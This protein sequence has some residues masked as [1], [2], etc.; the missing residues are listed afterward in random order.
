MKGQ[1][2]I[3]KALETGIQ[4][5]KSSE[6]YRQWLSTVSKFHRY[7][8][9]NLLLIAMQKP[10]ASQVAGYQTW[11]KLGRQVNGG[12]KGIK[13][14]CP[15]PYKKTMQDREGN[16]Q[17]V[18]GMAFAVGTVFDI[19]QTTGK[20]LPTL[21]TTLTADVGGY[22]ALKARLLTVPSVPVSF[23]EISGTAKG[24]C[25]PDEIKVNEGMSEAQT[26]KTLAH[27]IAHNLMHFDGAK[28]SKEQEETEAES[29]AYVVCDHLGID[30]SDYSFAYLATWGADKEFQNSLETIIK[31][32]RRII[33]KLEG[34][35]VKAA[36]QDFT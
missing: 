13:I 26:I 11:K 1:A 25:T 20:E 10:E 17:E 16:E 12:E 7:S 22:E 27:E 15:R 31:T 28:R 4:N 18:E 2:E 34:K 30:T 32:A 14:I 21:A 29:V 24:Y 35:E 33:D 8:L 9:N 23:G 19:S 6:G 5:V 3:K 36:W